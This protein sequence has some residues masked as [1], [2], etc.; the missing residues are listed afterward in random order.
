MST[1]KVDVASLKKAIDEFG[2]LRVGIEVLK[3]QKMALASEI[4]V[5]VKELEDAKAEKAKYVKELNQLKSSVEKE[6]QQLNSILVNINRYARQYH[7]FE[8]LMVML[9]TAPYGERDLEKLAVEIMLWAK[10]IWRTDQM[11]QKLRWLFVDSVLGKS[12][13][14]YRCNKCGAQFIVNKE[15]KSKYVGYCCP[16]CEL[17]YPVAADDS[18]LTAL[19]GSETPADALTGKVNSNSNPLN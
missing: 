10:T 5:L 15:P 12:L 17:T 11:P 18:F 9:L 2:S 16:V 14:C 13:H 1:S 4:S 8:S 6:S 7:L 3:K 19:V